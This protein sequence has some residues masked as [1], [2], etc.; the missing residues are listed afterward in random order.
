LARSQGEIPPMPATLSEGVP[1]TLR[2]ELVR[3]A[4]D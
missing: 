3:D 1:G 4:F 2:I